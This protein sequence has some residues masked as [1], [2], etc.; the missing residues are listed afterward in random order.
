MDSQFLIEDV[1]HI[2]EF[3]QK[4][5]SGFKKTDVI[6]I[7]LQSIE[8]GKLE[9]ACHW[10]VEC[11]VSG[12]SLDLLDK[13]IA[14]SSKLVHINNPKLPSYM[15]R[16]YQTMYQSINHINIKKQKYQLI[17]LRN[18]QVIRNGMI[19]IVSLICLSPKTKRYDKYPKINIT[20]D[21]QLQTIQKR[22]HAQ[23][24]FC[25]DMLF[26]FTDPEELR[27]V[28][29]EIMFHFKNI[30]VGYDQASYW[31]AWIFQWEKR[32]KKMKLPYE[33]DER[34]IRDIKQSHK[35]D[36]VWLLWSAI[37]I[38]GNTRDPDTKSQIQS[39]YTLFKYDYT[40][41]KRNLRIPLIYH[42]IGY[43]CYSVSF[44]IPLRYDAKPHIQCQC[45]VNG[46]FKLKKHNEIKGTPRTP[47][48][49]KKPEK[50]TIEQE[51][52]QDKLSV[53]TDI[54]IFVR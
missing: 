34:D 53:L 40:T 20:I 10:T 46:L 31:I 33:I 2:E 28:I 52:A 42:A 41:P 26:Q 22:L 32:R 3:K 37:L 23:A 17:H 51:K 11:I 44:S 39:L 50:I 8:T 38:E 27:I 13:L 36:V 30:N 15:L 24:N 5:F 1:R 9:N 19:D 45:K 47:P 29:N 21:F 25:P 49:K 6:K 54:D 7:L 14:F 4:S 43:L 18:S 16:R 12:Y 48:T 35:K